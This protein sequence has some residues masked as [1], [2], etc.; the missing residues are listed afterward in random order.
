[1]L[2]AV[3]LWTALLCTAATAAGC[4]HDAAPAGTHASFTDGGVTVRVTLARSTAR[5]VAVTATL[6]PQQPGFH[7]YSLGLPDQGIDGLGIPTRLSIAAP[8]TAAGEVTTASRPYNLRP[9]GLD[10]DLPV[11][12]DGP[13]TLHL[14]A[15][16][17]ATSGDRAGSAAT[18]ASLTARLRLTY[19]ACSTA[20][21]CL[22]PVRDH[23]VTLPVP[24]A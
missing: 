9:A 13:V 18:T 24:A 4:G 15:R 14:T 11:Y 10:V 7:L 6:S 20:G 17:A 8:L 2:S 19:G 22:A 1:V 21:G 5:T 3:L 23:A 16:L 12:P